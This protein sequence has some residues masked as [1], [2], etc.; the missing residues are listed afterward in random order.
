MTVDPCVLYETMARPRR[1]RFEKEEFPKGG[2]GASP[3]VFEV[4]I[5]NLELYSGTTSQGTQKH[6]RGGDSNQPPFFEQH[7]SNSLERAISVPTRCHACRKD[8]IDE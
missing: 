5:H 1:L 3:T 4:K 2:V 8:G 7:K 6:K